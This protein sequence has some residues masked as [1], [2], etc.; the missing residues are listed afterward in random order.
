MRY[1]LLAILIYV[2]Y[3]ILRIALRSILNNKAG[4]SGKNTEKTKRT[5]NLDEVQDAEYKEVKKDL[6]T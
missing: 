2:V 3:F 5:Y 6:T 1:V 4:V